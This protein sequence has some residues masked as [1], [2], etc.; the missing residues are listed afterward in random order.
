MQLLHVNILAVLA[1]G[2]A[3]WVL[4]YIWYGVLFKKDFQKLAHKD[5]AAPSGSAAGM[6]L[7][8]IANLILAF[9]LV[10]IVLLAGIGW[11]TWGSGSLVGVVC[12]LGFIVPPLFAQHIGENKAFKLFGINALYWLI[13]MYL[14]GG[15]LAVWR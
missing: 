8:L 12:G 15:I 3:Q 1:A 4:G 9:A 14:S 11:T 6:A 2:I 5:G 7:I 10:K 13:A